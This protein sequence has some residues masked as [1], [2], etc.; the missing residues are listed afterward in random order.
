VKLVLRVEW[1]KTVWTCGDPFHTKKFSNLSLEILVE[2]IVEWTI[3]TIILLIIIKFSLFVQNAL[4]ACDKPVALPLLML[5][6]P[7]KFFIN[8]LLLLQYIEIFVCF[9]RVL[10]NSGQHSTMQYIN[11][12]P[13]MAVAERFKSEYVVNNIMQS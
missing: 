6:K 11:I 2:W 12:Y 3:M 7:L 1:N 5:M 13:R 10:T 8:Q 9:S 4:P